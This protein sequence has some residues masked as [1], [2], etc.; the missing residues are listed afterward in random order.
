MNKPFDR[1]EFEQQLLNKHGIRTLSRVNNDDSDEVKFV[2]KHEFVP[3]VVEWLKEHGFNKLNMNGY[4]KE[5]VVFNTTWQMRVVPRGSP[6]NKNLPYDIAVVQI[7]NS[8]GLY[9]IKHDQMIHDPYV[10]G[11]EQLNEAYSIFEEYTKGTG[12]LSDWSF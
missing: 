8:S 5:E 10:R 6:R 4:K 2:K 11:I 9:T 12:T 1:E 7:P 3:P